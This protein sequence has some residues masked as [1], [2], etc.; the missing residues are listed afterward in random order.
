MPSAHQVDEL[1][2]KRVCTY[3]VR[4]RKSIFKGQ[5]LDDLGDYLNSSRARNYLKLLVTRHFANNEIRELEHRMQEA[6]DKDDGSEGILIQIEEE[7]ELEA[8]MMI[9][10]IRLTEVVEVE[11]VHQHLQD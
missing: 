4:I 2:H 11:G 7:K 3:L 9:P 5:N 1:S 10:P 8:P 6:D